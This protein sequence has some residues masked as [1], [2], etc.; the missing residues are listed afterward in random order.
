MIETVA[1]MAERLHQRLGFPSRI[2]ALYPSAQQVDCSL[3][4]VHGCKLLRQQGGE[5]PVL[6]GTAFLGA[7]HNH[8]ACHRPIEID[9]QGLADL[10]FKV[11]DGAIQRRGIASCFRQTF[12][13]GKTCAKA[14]RAQSGKITISGGV[15]QDVCFPGWIDVRFGA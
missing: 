6:G 2:V 15:I 14:R 9:R 13:D 12:G 1:G 8:N 3:R 11:R 7:T 4:D 5:F 10:I